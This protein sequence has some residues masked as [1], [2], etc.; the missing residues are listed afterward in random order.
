MGSAG[1]FELDQ[2][3]T[4]MINATRMRFIYTDQMNV[5]EDL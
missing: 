4:R 2:S 1:D 3:T 5:R